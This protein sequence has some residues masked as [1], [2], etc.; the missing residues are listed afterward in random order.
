MSVL[1]HETPTLSDDELR[2]KAAAENFPV[3]LRVLPRSEREDL[4]AI[5]GYARL[6]DDAGDE[7]DGGP[8]AR[9][10]A[11]QAIEEELGRAFSGTA[12][13]PLFVRLA[14]AIERRAMA[15]APFLDLI[16]ANR[17]DQEVSAY[18]RFEDLLGYCRLS[19]DP[20]GRLVLSVFGETSEENVRLSDLV[21][22]GLQIV[23]HLQDVREDAGRGRV[24]LPEEDLARF[25]VAAGS[26]AAP[27]ETTPPAVR[28]LVAFEVAR[29]RTMIEEGSRLVGRVRPSAATAIAAFAGG[30]LAQLAAIERAGYDV[31]ARAI[32]A[33]K[34][35]VATTTLRLLARRARRP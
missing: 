22:S 29:T 17:L 31:L 24:Y 32:K 23:E 8:Q 25:G 18:A 9:L 19:A 3:A 34:P 13:H 11:L 14:R 5:Y 33:G 15:R 35:M 12:T 16:E 30:G 26:L 4:F 7:L 27:T 10:V 2:A 6:V 20:V 28:R 21:C 1:T